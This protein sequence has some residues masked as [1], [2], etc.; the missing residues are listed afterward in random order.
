MTETNGT[1]ADATGT[2]PGGAGARY[3][4]AGPV[5]MLL[6]AA[7]IVSVDQVTKALAVWGLEGQDP[8]RIVGDS[9]RLLLL[10]NPGAA[11]SMGTGSTVVLSIVATVVVLGLL[12]FSRR[13]HSR[14]WA[15]GLGLIL[16]GAAGNLVDRYLRSPGVLRGHVV[17]FVSV[18]WWPVFNVA[19]SSLVVGV[20]VVA[21]AVFKAVEFDGSRGPVEKDAAATEPRDGE[22]GSDTG[23][24]TDG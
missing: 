12:W 23:G 6:I 9:V 13:I 24:R 5:V 3:F 18:G 21:V 2:T 1:R 20:I 4:R 7:V 15:W 14:W 17:D 19:D 16:G 8:I 11:F 22:A 10:R